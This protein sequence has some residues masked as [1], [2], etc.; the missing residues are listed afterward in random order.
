M[1]KSTFADL[2]DDL[3]ASGTL[4]ESLF[5]A[6]RKEVQKQMR[7]RGVWSNSPALLGYPFSSWKEPGA[8]D[9]IVFDVLH[10]AVIAHQNSLAA[11]RQSA[12][13]FDGLIANNIRFFLD[14][15]QRAVDPSGRNVHNCVV[16]VVKTG[17]TDGW[18][19]VVGG[20]RGVGLK[21]TVA[22]ASDSSHEPTIDAIR[23]ALVSTPSFH[24]F[25][26]LLDIN[27][28][29]ERKRLDAAIAALTTSF[30]ALA[31]TTSGRIRV[32]TL[33]KAVKLEV[34][35][36]HGGVSPIP[37]EGVPDQIVDPGRG[38]ELV[39]TCSRINA[40][41]AAIRD[42]SAPAKTKEIRLAVLDSLTDPRLVDLSD[43][44]RASKLGLPRQRYSEHLKE[45]RGIAL[46]HV[47]SSGQIPRQRR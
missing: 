8:L 29:L 30:R 33:F 32:E 41:E 31:A 36:V 9:A 21:T 18:L 2:F 45:I 24:D 14:D 47:E 10:E 22:P 4:S 42:S 27:G 6:V 25:V 35:A 19:F 43:A 11:R 17:V 23:C 7:G 15:R 28:K 34:R 16:S 5:A 20:P 44:E 12:E 13:Y 39:E 1:S 3:R 26:S 40:I 46:E 38:E 37:E